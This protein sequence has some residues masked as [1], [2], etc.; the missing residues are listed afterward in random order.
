MT[1]DERPQL[2][3]A[4]VC[5]PTLPNG[6]LCNISENFVMF[7]E[8]FNVICLPLSLLTFIYQQTCKEVLHWTRGWTLAINTALYGLSCLPC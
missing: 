6:S 2:R 1:G 8:L 5:A 4:I 7:P 3:K